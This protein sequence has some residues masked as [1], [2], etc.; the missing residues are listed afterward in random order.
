MVQRGDQVNQIQSIHVVAGLG[1]DV[2]KLSL[3]QLYVER[4]FAGLASLYLKFTPQYYSN[5]DEIYQDLVKAGVA[6][7]YL[8]PIGHSVPRARYIYDEHPADFLDAVS[9]DMPVRIPC[10]CRP[11][12]STDNIMQLWSEAIRNRLAN[13]G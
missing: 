13:D 10:V 12:M 11:D 9:D 8:L 3:D 2:S 4:L 7:D 5:I 1:N 6:P